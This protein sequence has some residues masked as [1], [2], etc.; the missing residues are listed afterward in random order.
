MTGGIWDPEL[1]YAV[2]PDVDNCREG[3]LSQQAKNRA[4]EVVNQ[5]RKLHDLAPLRYS[6]IYNNQV[7]K[8]SL[9]Q[10][11]NNTTIFDP[12]TSVKC[13]TQEGRNGSYS[14]LISWRSEE[15]ADPAIH[16]IQLLSSYNVS[17]RRVILNP[18]RTYFTY[19]QVKRFTAQK[20]FDF[21]SEPTSIPQIN[22][23][24][25]AYPYEKY[26]F[27][28]LRDNPRWSFSVVAD[29]KNLW[30]NQGDF[31]KNASITVTRASDGT[32]LTTSNHY[33]DSL[34][35]GLPNLLSWNVEGWEFDTLYEVEIKNV[36]LKDRTTQ[37]Y[38]YPVFVQKQN[39]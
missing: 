38:S 25:V 13:Y 29:K 12:D 18:F 4:L 32:Q 28:L 33:T 39:L 9:I 10:E 37:N 22:V 36:T 34:G 7:Q 31:F 17:S 5:I 6:S 19:G 14:S 20:T 30:N 21:D 16:I 15:N 23:N 2:E 1:L 35:Y 3:R 8:A 27:N 11:A 26:P 24:F